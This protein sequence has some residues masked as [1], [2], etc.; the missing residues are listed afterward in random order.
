MNVSTFL[1]TELLSSRV[2]WQCLDSLMSKSNWACKGVGGPKFSLNTR[3]WCRDVFGGIN[4]TSY[5]GSIPAF[6][7]SFLP[8]LQ[9]G[10][11]DA[12]QWHGSDNDLLIGKDA[13]CP[14]H[15]SMTPAGRSTAASPAGALLGN[16]LYRAWTQRSL[17]GYISVYTS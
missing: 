11:Q 8:E 12:H 5:M 14:V 6:P 16:Y 7:P 9:R 17:S 13:G 2:K 4:N 10:L 15:I 1:S 3:L